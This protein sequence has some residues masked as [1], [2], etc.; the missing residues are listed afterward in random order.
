MNER[1]RTRPVLAA[2]TAAVAVLLAA[3]SGGGGGRDDEGRI[4]EPTDVAVFDLRVGD[5]LA[6]D[7]GVVA[8]LEEVRAVPCEDPHLHEVFFLAEWDGGDTFPGDTAL[9]DFADGAC[10]AEFEAYVGTDYLDSALFHTYLLPTL[11][12]W[13]ERNDRQ[14]VCLAASAGEPLQGSSRGSER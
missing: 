4:T 3:C 5:C 9:A 8:E 13:D 14:V 12:S 7:Q 6:P 10:I 2:A 11:R 1:A